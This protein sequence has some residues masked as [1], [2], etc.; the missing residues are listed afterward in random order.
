MI[1]VV[2]AHVGVPGLASLDPLVIPVVSLVIVALSTGYQLWS[3]RTLYL[4]A[5]L[6]G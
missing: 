1:A 4:H 5:L 2:G 6:R 3:R